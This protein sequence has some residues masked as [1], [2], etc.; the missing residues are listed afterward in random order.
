MQIV[1][2]RLLRHGDGTAGDVENILPSTRR[3]GANTHDANARTRFRDTFLSQFCTSL[4]WHCQGLALLWENDGRPRTMS[5]AVLGAGLEGALLMSAAATWLS[6]RRAWAA[7]GLLVFVF[8]N[9]STAFLISNVRMMQ[10]TGL[11]TLPSMFVVNSGLREARTFLKAEVTSDQSGFLKSVVGTYL[12]ALPALSWIWRQRRRPKKGAE[13]VEVDQKDGAAVAD[14]IEHVRSNRIYLVLLFAATSI[15][16]CANG[17]MPIFHTYASVCGSAVFS[18]PG[19]SL[20]YGRKMREKAQREARKAGGGRSP[21]SDRPNVILIVHESLSG[22]YTLARE[23]A[24]GLM[25]FFQGK[26]RA[27]DGEFFVLE[28]SRSVSGDTAECVP[29]KPVRFL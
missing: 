10:Y 20:E 8:A 29:G 22:E 7:N 3:T 9:V 15:A 1:T 2:R 21:D 6:R 5:L 14:H 27:D 12:C 26:F 11:T 25:P 18:P 23:D 16:Y 13:L 17:W 24:A 19:S 4:L 28:H